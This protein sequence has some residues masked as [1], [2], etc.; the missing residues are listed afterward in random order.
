MFDDYVNG[1]SEYAHTIEDYENQVEKDIYSSGTGSH[2]PLMLEAVEVAWRTALRD[3]WDGSN[4][5]AISYTTKVKADVFV[6][7][8]PIGISEAPIINAEADG[9]IGFDWEKETE[10]LSILVKE[11]RLVYSAFLKDD[12]RSKGSLKLRNRLS[13][14]LIELIAYFG[15]A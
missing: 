14:D 5:R 9:A 1:A 7:S 6:K 15:Q 2:V 11:G 10:S 8:F 3:N 4:S 13:K 12:E